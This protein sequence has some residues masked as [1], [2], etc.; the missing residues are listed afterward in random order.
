MVIY[1]SRKLPVEVRIGFITGMQFIST[2]LGFRGGVSQ[3]G[4]CGWAGGCKSPPID[5]A[6][7]QTE[8]YFTTFQI[9]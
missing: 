8:K 2:C 1:I 6:I 9:F 5:F 4:V 3:V 7:V